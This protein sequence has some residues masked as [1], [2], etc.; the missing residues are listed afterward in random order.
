MEAQG[1]W[2][3]F[4][5]VTALSLVSTLDKKETSHPPSAAPI[6]PGDS[7]SRVPAH[8]PPSCLQGWR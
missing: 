1:T 6:K 8:P 4:S 3:E 5:G 7:S 2:Q